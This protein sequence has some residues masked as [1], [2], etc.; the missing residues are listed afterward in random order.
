MKFIKQENTERVLT[1]I[2]AILDILE[3][4]PREA[5]GN[6][7]ERVEKMSKLYRATAEIAYIVSGV[8][9]LNQCIVFFNKRAQSMDEVLA[10]SKAHLDTLDAVSNKKVSKRTCKKVR[11]KKCH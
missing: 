10:V 8:H 2:M 1:L 5:F 11:K 3:S 6:S 7:A 4:I 9:G